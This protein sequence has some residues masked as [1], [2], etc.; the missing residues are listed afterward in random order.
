MPLAGDYLHIYIGG[1]F[2][3]HIG[4]Q[5]L[6]SMFMISV[7]PDSVVLPRDPLSSDTQKGSSF[8]AG[9]SQLHDRG[10]KFC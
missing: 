1:L 8:T 5:F 3:K 2:M 6:L 7:I 10:S 4:F 9:N